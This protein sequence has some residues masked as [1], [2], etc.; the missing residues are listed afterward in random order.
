MTSTRRVRACL[1]LASIAAS[2]ALVGCFDPPLG[3]PA[4]GRLV[5]G[6]LLATAGEARGRRALTGPAPSAPPAGALTGEQLHDPGD[7]L[8]EVVV[9]EGVGEAGVARRAEGLTGH[10]GH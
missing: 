2:C 5:G 7:A 3:R 10:D 4:G 1:A 8:F 6:R 9:A